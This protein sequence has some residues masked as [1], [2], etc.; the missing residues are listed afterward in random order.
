MIRAH[1]DNVFDIACDIPLNALNA[2]FNLEL[3]G[4]KVSYSKLLK[5]IDEQGGYDISETGGKIMLSFVPSFPEA[6]EK[7]ENT[8]PPRVVMYGDLNDG[9]VTFSLV[10]VEDDTKTRTKDASEAELTYRSWIAFIE[11]NY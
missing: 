3:A 1:H 8:S 5:Y 6:I 9:V 7:G 10:Q 2:S 11:E 4:L